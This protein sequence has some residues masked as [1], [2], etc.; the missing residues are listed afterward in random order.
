MTFSASV[1]NLFDT[2]GLTEVEEAS[3]SGSGVIRARSIAGR[4]ASIGLRY[5]F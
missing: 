3:F 2:F 1:N 4:T 5:D